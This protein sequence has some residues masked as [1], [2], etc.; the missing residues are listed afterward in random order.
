M[1][2]ILSD[3]SCTKKPLIFNEFWLVRA[4]LVG[5][6]GTTMLHTHEV[7]GSSPVVSTKNKTHPK[8]MG[9]IFGIGI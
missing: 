7:T 6:I 2:G 9:F 4:S 8:G 1:H 5:P 3:F